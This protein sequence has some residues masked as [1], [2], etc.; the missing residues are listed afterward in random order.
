MRVSGSAI[1]MIFIDIATGFVGLFTD[2]QN[3]PAGDRV[4]VS[5]PHSATSHYIFYRARTGS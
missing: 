2:H 5:D 4:H 3:T 1:L